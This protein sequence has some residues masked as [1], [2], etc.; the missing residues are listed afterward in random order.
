M[1]I[2]ILILILLLGLA[3]LFV[4]LARAAWRSRHAILRWPGV[5]LAGLLALAITVVSVIAIVGLV[6]LNVAPYQYA[7]TA[8]IPVTGGPGDVE[9]GAK[10]AVLCT[11]CHSSTGNLPLDGSAD[12]FLAGGPPLGSLYPPNLTPGGPLKDWTDADIARAIREGV[13]KNGQ[14]LLIMP[15]K[16]FH[17]LS[18]EDTADIIAFLRSQPAVNRQLPQKQLTLLAAGIV[19]AG[20]FSTSAQPPITGPV[21]MPAAGTA[22]KGHYLVTSMGCTDCH[23]DHLTG[24]PAGGFG[25][26]GPNLTA[27]VP[28]W[29]EEDLVNLFRTGKDPSGSHVSDNMPWKEYNGVFSDADLQDIFSYLHGL[30]KLPNLQ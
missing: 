17:N 13:D 21:N 23:G 28:K 8:G 5:V 20:I 30:Q 24:V 9:R 18:D 10:L 19:G 7:T 3:I 12:N 27:I 16:A 15:S 1:L 14:P 26:S 29:K 2:N 4:F 11:G 25:P 22:D 6:R